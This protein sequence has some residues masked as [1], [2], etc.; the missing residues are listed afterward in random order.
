MKKVRKA[1]EDRDSSV[2]DVPADRLPKRADEVWP[3]RYAPPAWVKGVVCAMALETE[4]R[5]YE[6]HRQEFLPQYRNLFVLIKKD[7]LVGVFSD[8]QTAHREGLTQFGLKPFLVKQVLENEPISVSPALIT[9]DMLI[10]SDLIIRD[11]LPSSDTG[12]DGAIPLPPPTWTPEPDG[13]DWA[14]QNRK[15]NDLLNR[16]ADP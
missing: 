7:K 11:T 9:E 15:I 8:A 4:L 12:L 3:G 6:V 1:A 10:P 5:F 14:E 2:W 16:P 13:P